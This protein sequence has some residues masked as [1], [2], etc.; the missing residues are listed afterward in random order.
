MLQNKLDRTK[1]T[2]EP[3]RIN[4]KI[5]ASEV[6]LVGDNIVNGVYEISEAMKMAQR[7]ELDLVEISSKAEPPVCRILNYLKFKYEQKKK[8]KEIFSNA[9]KTIVKEVRLSPNI[10]EHDFKFKLIHAI[11]FLKDGANVRVTLLFIGRAVAYKDRG[12]LL[13][14]RFAKELAEYGK[15]DQMPRMD[16]KERRGGEKM[17]LVMSPKIEKK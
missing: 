1:K 3:F 6:R 8:Q 2:E 16:G 4:E 14:L 9:Q 11:G 7:Q 12:E 13:L 10:A 5:L 15:V 17:I